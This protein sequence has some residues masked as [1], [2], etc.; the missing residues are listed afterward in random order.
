MNF[1]VLK[2][3]SATL[4]P[5]IMQLMNQT[6]QTARLYI[7][8]TPI[9]NL[10]DMTLRAIEVLK[11]VDLILAEDTRQTGKLLQHYQI[12]KPI[13]S[14]HQHNERRVVTRVLERL[15][16]GDVL[17]LVSDAGTPLI[18]DP[19]QVVVQAVIDAGYPVIPIPGVSALTTALSVSGFSADR[20]LFEGFLPS[21]TGDRK[22]C[23]H[24]LAQE[25]RSLVFFESPHRI[26]ASLTDMITC[27]GEQ[28]RVMVGRE[29][30]KL[31]ET[32]LHGELGE[33]L[34]RVT[35][36]PN[37]RRGEFVIVVAGN[38]VQTN[39]NAFD[40]QTVLE[41]LLQELPSKQAASLAA[42][43]TGGRKNKLYQMAIKNTASV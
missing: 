4:F 7:V 1:T 11:Q 38:P 41:I 5:G 12:N 13:I 19:G 21:K 39:T 10:Q 30:T 37:Q 29:M 33:L 42:K 26:T 3:L 40:A 17:G 31:F 16:A 9:G 22:R 18:R 34:H 15:A 14:A 8:A 25:T 43:I 36:D 32:Y 27:F 28:R 6:H 35:E 24:A 20:F 23:L 2:G